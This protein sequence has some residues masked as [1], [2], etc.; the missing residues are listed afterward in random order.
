MACAASSECSTYLRKKLRVMN[1]Q[2]IVLLRK[3]LSSKMKEIR[4]KLRIGV[5]FFR[6]LHEI[7]CSLEVSDAPWDFTCI[8]WYKVSPL[9]FQLS[10]LQKGENF[11]TALIR[12]T[13]F[14]TSLLNRTVELNRIYFVKRL[15]GWSLLKSIMPGRQ[16]LETRSSVYENASC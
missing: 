5:V 13:T 8:G 11:G 1:S 16:D 12:G 4:Q 14:F 2:A 7:L 6:S 9:K 3:L 10:W 15:F